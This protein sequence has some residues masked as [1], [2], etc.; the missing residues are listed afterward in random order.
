M[1]LNAR[2]LDLL[3]YALTCAIR[4]PANTEDYPIKE[5][6]TLRGRVAK[7]IIAP[8]M[9]E[10]LGVEVDFGD[11]GTLMVLVAATHMIIDAVTDGVPDGF[12]DFD[13]MIWSIVLRDAGQSREATLQALKKLRDG[14]MLH[15]Q[16][17]C[18]EEDRQKEGVSKH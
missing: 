8:Q 6:D 12:D 3:G 16:A 5:L 13:R 15:F 11:R 18:A 4:R 1:K 9:A 10:E 2:E 17:A 14:L 7:E